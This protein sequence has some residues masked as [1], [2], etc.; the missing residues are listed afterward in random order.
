[1]A[2]VAF[3]RES[4]SRPPVPTEPLTPKEWAA[5]GT[6]IGEPQ[7]E[8]VPEH[9]RFHNPAWNLSLFRTLAQ[10]RWEEQGGEGELE[11]PDPIDTS[12]YSESED[13]DMVDKMDTTVDEE[14]SFAGIA[15]TNI[16]PEGRMR[17]K[18]KLDYSGMFMPL[19]ELDDEDDGKKKHRSSVRDIS[20]DHTSNQLLLGSATPPDSLPKPQHKR[21]GRPPRK[22][23]LTSE[24]I[25][26][27]DDLSQSEDTPGESVS[28]KGVPFLSELSAIPPPSISGLVLPSTERNNVT[29][30]KKR[31][32]LAPGFSQSTHRAIMNTINHPIKQ[33]PP[34]EEKTTDQLTT[35]LPEP[36]P[37]PIRK[38]GSSSPTS[39]EYESVSSESQETTFPSGQLRLADLPREIAA[40]IPKPLEFFS[41]RDHISPLIGGN[42]RAVV[43]TTSA[44]K[45]NAPI[46]TKGYMAIQPA[47]NPHAPRKAGENGSMMQLSETSTDPISK[48]QKNFP[49][50]VARRPHQWEY[51]GQYKV[52]EVVKLSAFE[53]WMHLST[54][55]SKLLRHWGESILQKRFEWAK[56]MFM[57]NCGWNEEKW[58]TAA[59]EDIMG[60]ILAGTV[61]MHWVHL[62]C[63]GF[64]LEFYEALLRQKVKCGLAASQKIIL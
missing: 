25:S 61:P 16:L 21:R 43:V 24:F 63:V 7:D 36:S 40:T 17:K 8:Q 11:E 3:L 15:A 59:V 57:Q 31:V 14:G 2:R 39:S 45:P 5:F 41:R 52:A 4:T 46:Q 64:D 49:L 55:G 26:E 51:C 48:T 50:F 10:K 56:N 20:E 44:G 28:S 58:R 23:Q 62:Q 53:N 12:A 38:A 54:G 33:T 6:A 37:P 32:S 18:A 13:I 35:S 29:G 34:T 27:V 9:L 19:H 47:W 60:P 30:Y 1:M 42:L 22:P